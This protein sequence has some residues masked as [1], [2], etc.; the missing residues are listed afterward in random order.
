[1]LQIVSDCEWLC[2]TFYFAVALAFCLSVLAHLFMVCT[3]SIVLRQHVNIRTSQSPL[4]KPLFLAKPLPSSS[5]IYEIQHLTGLLQ[6]SPAQKQS[7]MRTSLLSWTGVNHTAGRPTRS[8]LIRSESG[9]TVNTVGA[10][11]SIN[12]KHPRSPTPPANLPPNYTFP[13]TMYTT[14]PTNPA[15]YHPFF[16]FEGLSADTSDPRHNNILAIHIQYFYQVCQKQPTVVFANQR[17][18][19]QTNGNI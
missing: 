7:K 14:S 15:P 2:S 10:A 13:P 5:Q 17:S 12:K 4:Q 19:R 3:V 11:F 9:F 8:C 18:H 6:L 1:M 16:R